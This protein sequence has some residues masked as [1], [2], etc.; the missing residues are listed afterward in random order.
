MN[1]LIGILLIAVALGVGL[2]ACEKREPTPA[3]PEGEEQTSTLPAA[4]DEHEEAHASEGVPAS[5][6]EMKDVSGNTVKLADL[7]GQKGVLF[8]FFATWCPHCMEEV[9]ELIAFTERFKGRKIE[10]I[11]AAIDQ[12]AHVIE[13]FAKERKVNYRLVL[14]EDGKV[15]DKYGVR[16]IPALFGISLDG[17]IRWM[18]HG[19]PEDQEKLVELLESGAAPS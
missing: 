11:A 10:V 4:D 16:G 13:K 8:V 5:A 3:R 12:P 7:S 14:D 18:G 6:W 19:L 9:P 2:I 17:R 1:R 15:A